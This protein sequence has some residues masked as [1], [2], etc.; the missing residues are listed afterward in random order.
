MGIDTLEDTS[1]IFYIS[2]SNRS[3]TSTTSIRYNNFRNLET[4]RNNM[5]KDGFFGN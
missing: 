3:A 4:A 2:L 5:L 1:G